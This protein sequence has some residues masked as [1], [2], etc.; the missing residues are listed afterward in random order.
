LKCIITGGAGFIGSHLVDKI[1]DMGGEVAIID[2]LITGSEKNINK[3][4]TFYNEDICNTKRLN[5]IFNDFQPDFVFH[6]AAQINVRKSMENPRYD[7]EVNIL[8]SLNIIKE[9]LNCNAKR[10]IFA[11]SG[12]TIYGEPEYRP[13]KEEHPKVPIAQYG[14]S[15]YTIEEYLRIF[16][17]QRDLSYIALRYANIYGPRQNP[18][19]Q[20][21]VFAIFATQMLSG[22][23]PVIFGDG[24]ATRDYVYV[25]DAVDS[26]IKCI[27]D[28]KDGS[29]NIGTEV[30]VSTNEVYEFLAEEIGFSEKPDRGEYRPGEIYRISLDST[31]AKKELNFI[32]KISLQKGVKKLIEHYKNE[33]D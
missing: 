31:L 21:G 18:K 23:K 1:I 26:A 4:A 13:V 6:F 7:A 2:N 22:E 32:P 28:V 11:S 14:L 15:K 17:K 27:S 19:G 25:D 5:E 29:Y 10:L 8:G 9:T 3:N 24:T 33:L 16:K 12:G 30:E 20:A